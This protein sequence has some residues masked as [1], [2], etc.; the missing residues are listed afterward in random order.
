MKTGEP[1][2]QNT[3]LVITSTKKGWLQQELRLQDCDCSEETKL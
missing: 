3:A 2:L 1:T